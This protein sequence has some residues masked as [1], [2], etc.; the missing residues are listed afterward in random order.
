M[1]EYFPTVVQ[2]IP[3]RNYHVHVFFDDGKIV[4][5]DVT[6]DL[7][8]EEGDS[9]EFALVDDEKKQIT[10][11]YIQCPFDFKGEKYVE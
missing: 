8:Y 2:V 10:Y 9:N 6:D 1:Q 3:Q 7:Q 11:V 4:D 5:Y